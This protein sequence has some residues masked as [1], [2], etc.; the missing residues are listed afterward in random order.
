MDACTLGTRKSHI[1]YDIRKGVISATV[2][3][4]G[5]L[6]SER[7]REKE[8]ERE[9]ERRGINRGPLFRGGTEKQAGS[10]GENKKTAFSVH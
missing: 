2:T 5:G 1:A 4:S 9:R 7:K 3:C 10:R 6:Y 8:R